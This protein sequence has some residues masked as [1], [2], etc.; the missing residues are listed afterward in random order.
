MSFSYIPSRAISA[1]AARALEEDF[2]ADVAITIR[3][4]VYNSSPGEVSP[5]RADTVSKTRIIGFALTS[6]LAGE[7]V[8][9][10]KGGS[11][12]GFAGL[13]VNS[14]IFLGPTGGITETLPTGAT[15]SVVQLGT[16][17]S[18]TKIDIDIQQLVRRGT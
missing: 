13:T 14:R 6:V 7:T 15:E 9:V 2:I 1:D 17:R 3:D 12:D 4:P 18:T 10:R 5:G 8:T 11:L 16:A